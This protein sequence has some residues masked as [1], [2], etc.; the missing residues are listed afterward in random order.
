MA[1]KGKA[2]FKHN[3]KANCITLEAVLVRSDGAIQVRAVVPYEKA[4]AFF[5]SLERD[6]KVAVMGGCG[7]N[8][9]RASQALAARAAVGLV[10]DAA[11][12]A[13][14]RFAAVLEGWNPL[15]SAYGAAK[16]ARDFT[17]KYSPS[18]YAAR[19][20]RNKLRRKKGGSGAPKGGA[21]KGGGGDG[22]GGDEGEGDDQQDDQEQ[23]EGAEAPEG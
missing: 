6:E 21:P 10:Q 3:R 7:G 2:T 4:K 13:A 22:G 19:A 20:L 12:F 8:P 23:Q 11:D 17:T 14:D 9:H 16:K 15:K 1:T 5:A 18:H